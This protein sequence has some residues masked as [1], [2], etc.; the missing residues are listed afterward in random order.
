MQPSIVGNIEQ[1]NKDRIIAIQFPNATFTIEKF[2]LNGTKLIVYYANEETSNIKKEPYQDSY[3]LSGFNI[4]GK[5][6]EVEFIYSHHIQLLEI[7]NFKSI[8]IL[9]IACNRINIFVGKPNVG[10]SNLLEALGLYAINS[11]NMKGIDLFVRNKIY[12]NLFFENDINNIIVINSNKK[13]VEIAIN[14]LSGMPDFLLDQRDH[15]L[16]I[17]PYYFSKRNTQKNISEDGSNVLFEQSLNSRVLKF[18]NGE[19]FLEVIQQNKPL[20]ETIASYFIPYGLEFLVDASDNKIEIQKRQEG[21]VFKIPYELMADT[22]QRMIFYMA[23]ILSN[24]NAVLVFEEPEAHA[25]PPFIKQFGEK[26]L[27]SE[28]NQ[29]F[30][31]THNPYILNTLLE[32]DKNNEVNLFLVDYK[33]HQTTIQLIDIEERSQMLTHGIDIFFNERWFQQL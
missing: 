2:E 18:P 8:K 25:Y 12:N 22:L 31:A 13:K 1:I 16:R 26:I 19:N 17:R 6:D 21:L 11:N 15:Y 9:K 4:K 32:N 14:S 28:T 3:Y 27:E 24:Q 33:D 29:F 10:K 20:R 5:I 23:A 30:L 7:H